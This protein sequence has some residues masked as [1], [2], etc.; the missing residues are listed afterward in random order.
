MTDPV[1]LVDVRNLTVDFLPGG[2][3]LR[4]VAGLDL[5][6]RAGEVLAVLGESGSGKTVTL[7]A[8]MRLLPERR[9]VIGGHIVVDGRD[10][11]ALSRRELSDYCGR[12]VAM[13][14]QEPGLALDPVYRVGAGG[15][16]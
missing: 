16:C 15:R 13:V 2:T 3:S 12:T 9:T 1:Q 11:L 4:A 10:V 6:L 5:T 14:F 8:L 7:R